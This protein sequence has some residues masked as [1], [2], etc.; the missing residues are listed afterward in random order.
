M[1]LS[2]S[3]FY[4]DDHAMIYT[5]KVTADFPLRLYAILVMSSLCVVLQQLLLAGGMNGLSWKT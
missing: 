3:A 2:F 5:P 1:P 4:Y